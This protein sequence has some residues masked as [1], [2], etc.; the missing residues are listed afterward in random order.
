M[1][2]NPRIMTCLSSNTICWSIVHIFA[3]ELRPMSLPEMARVYIKTGK[4]FLVG[5]LRDIHRLMLV[6]L[7]PKKSF[8]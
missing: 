6:C 4:H 7:H 1:I 2:I 3:S 8:Q 5:I